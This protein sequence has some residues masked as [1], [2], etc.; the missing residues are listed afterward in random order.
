MR[1]TAKTLGG[2][3]VSAAL[4]ALL[5]ACGGG[6]G[7]NGSTAAPTG[8]ASKSTVATTPAPVS[9]TLPAQPVCE[10]F[11]KDAI[12]KLIGMPVY[13]SS[14][15][16]IAAGAQPSLCYYYIDTREVNSVE[17]HLMTLQQAAWEQQLGGI[18]TV[19]SGNMKTVTTRYTELGDDGL[20]GVGTNDLVTTTDY[21]VLLK[22]R[23]LVVEVTGGVTLASN[24]TIP[25]A[26]LIDVMKMVIAAVEKL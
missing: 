21:Q 24:A 6:S 2:T 25:D 16:D 17:I 8:G 7:T 19:V 5:A 1:I 4:V 12:S 18:G 10:L 11:S 14:D 22:S 26:R 3:V 15:V 23:G 20:K 9:T 13:S